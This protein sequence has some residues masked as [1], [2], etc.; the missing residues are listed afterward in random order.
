MTPEQLIAEGRA[1][2]RP[3]V[4]LEF[5]GTGPVAGVWYDQNDAAEPDSPFR[6]WLSVNA[7]HI[8]PLRGSVH[9]VLSVFTDEKK[10][11][12]GRVEHSSSWPARVGRPLYARMVD[13]LP[14]IE[15]VF[16]KGSAEV[17]AW[18]ES[19]GWRREDRYS[20]GFGGRDVVREYEKVFFR[21]YPIYLQRG[22][23][24]TLGGWHMPWPDD[25]WHD[26]LDEELLVCTMQDSEPWVE[27]WHLGNGDMKVIQRIT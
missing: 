27:V 7:E 11:V 20:D 13:V 6:C 25:D 15:A 8:P 10:C 19:F 9:G 17:G 5:S 12:G 23:G 1:I 16:A 21:E 22:P 14:P 4:F 3:C 26:L 18:I 2:Q 24:A